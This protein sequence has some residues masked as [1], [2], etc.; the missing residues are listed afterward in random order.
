MV[1]KPKTYK[2]EQIRRENLSKYFFDL[3]KLSF[4][5][6]AAGGITPLFLNKGYTPDWFLMVGGVFTVAVLAITG[7]YILR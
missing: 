7:Y 3:S 5:V 2:K 6:L 1:Q 4:G